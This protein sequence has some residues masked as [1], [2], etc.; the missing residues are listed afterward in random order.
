MSSQASSENRIQHLVD[1]ILGFLISYFVTFWIILR[2]PRTSLHE[3]LQPDKTSKDGMLPGAF[4]VANILLVYAIQTIFG[5][6]LPEF[7]LE[8]PWTAQ[9]PIDF[10][11]YLFGLLVILIFLLLLLS[12]RDFPQGMTLIVPVACYASIVYLP[13]SLVGMLISRIYDQLI[14]SA[15]AVAGNIF[16]SGERRLPSIEWFYPIAFIVLIVLYAACVLWW[17]YL[18]HLGLGSINLQ[19]PYNG[20]WK[21]LFVAGFYYLITKGVSV[22]LVGTIL[23]WST[24]ATEFRWKELQQ[25]IL[26]TPEE[27]GTAYTLAQLINANDTFFVYPR[28]VAS[29]VAATCQMAIFGPSEEEKEEIEWVIKTMKESKFEAAR[30]LLRNYLSKFT[31]DEAGGRKAIYLMSRK[32]LD[33]SDELYKSPGFMKLNNPVTYFEPPTTPIALFP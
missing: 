32:Y 23:Y 22:I 19:L 4:L 12:P 2:N 6:S 14:L 31:N 1:D 27:C 24:I 33:K 28:Y 20:R 25:V 18:I 3:L 30:E 26:K 29:I 17:L 11:R 5:F 8:L 9:F 15:T 10:L 16:A 7:P 13:L 21:K